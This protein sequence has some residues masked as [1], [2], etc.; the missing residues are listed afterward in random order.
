MG[1]DRQHNGLEEGFFPERQGSRSGAKHALPRTSTTQK[2]SLVALIGLTILF[3]FLDATIFS[4][5][6]PA[7]DWAPL[8]VAGHLSWTNAGLAYDADLV[9]SLQTPLIGTTSDRP[10]IYP[11]SALLLFAPFSM[12]PFT[13]AFVIFGALSVALYTYGAQVMKPRPILLLLAPPF[14]L[15]AMAGQPTLL[16]AALILFGLAQLDRNEGWAG[17]LLAIAAMIKP[18]LLLLAPVALAGGSYW[19][20]IA[21]AGATATAIAGVSLAVF[22]VDAWFAWLSA[23]P[24]FKAL[25]TEFQPLLRNAVTPYAMAVRLDVPP[26]LATACAALVAI[27]MAWWSFS[28]TQDTGIRLAALVG[29][30]L[31]VS[32]YAMNYE[33]AA[34]APIVAAV[35]LDR[36]GDLIMPAIWAASLFMTVSLAG[37]LA[38]YA[39][40][41]LR[42][43][44]QWRR[45]AT[46][47]H[48]RGMW[49][50]AQRQAE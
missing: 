1:E 19:R 39:W 49:Q 41:L 5:F 24:A 21:A 11:P 40:A 37:L 22:G 47:A 44:S 28:R 31:L 18:P 45:A 3:V 4:I 6:K 50:P 33:L 13:V 12:L 20:A 23:L 46:G 14:V 30:A 10:F 17:V 25:V 43:S 34:L 48:D 27:P 42:L 26:Y 35:R 16:V 38:V 8:W 2:W 15:A 32:P 9:S 36:P 29:G 7:T